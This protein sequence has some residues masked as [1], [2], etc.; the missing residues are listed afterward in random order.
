[1]KQVSKVLMTV[2][3]AA[4]LGGCAAMGNDDFSCSGPTPGV[5]CLPATEV[6]EI[7]SDPEL[8]EAVRVELEAAAASGE[9]FNAMEIVNRVKATYQPPVEVSKAMAGPVKQPLPVLQPAHVIRIWFDAWVDEKS[10]LH[11]PGYV[12]TEITP[13]RWSLGDPAVSEAQV[14]APVQVDND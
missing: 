8:Y 14:L 6:Y 3:C 9:E 12:F 11:M 2:A 10:D 7:T 1:M 4:A 5:A 13:R